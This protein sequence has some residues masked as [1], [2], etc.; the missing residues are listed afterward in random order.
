MVAFDSN[1]VLRRLE[2]RD[3]TAL[4][5]TLAGTEALL[6]VYLIQQ[7]SKENDAIRFVQHTELLASHAIEC[8]DS[9][10]LIRRSTQFAGE[11]WPVCYYNSSV[12][13]W[14][15]AAGWRCGP[16]GALPC[17]ILRRVRFEPKANENN[18]LSDAA[19]DSTA[20][21]VAITP[22][23]E[24]PANSVVGAPSRLPRVRSRDTQCLAEVEDVISDDD[25]SKYTL[26]IDESE[27]LFQPEKWRLTLE[28][29]ESRVASV[30]AKDEFRRALLRRLRQRLYEKLCASVVQGAVRAEESTEDAMRRWI[31][32]DSQ[33]IDILPETCPTL[34][35]AV[36]KARERPQD[37][38]VNEARRARQL[39]RSACVTAV[40]KIT[41]GRTFVCVDIGCAGAAVVARS[42][43]VWLVR[44]AIERGVPFFDDDDGLDLDSNANIL[45]I[46][47]NDDD[48]AETLSRRLDD[49]RL[50]RP[51][52][53]A[54]VRCSSRG[55]EALQRRLRGREESFPATLSQTLHNA[56]KRMLRRLDE[57]NPL[58]R[59]RD[60]T[61]AA[62]PAVQAVDIWLKELVFG[63][64]KES[65]DI[66]VKLKLFVD[67]SYA[68]EERN[69]SHTG[70]AAT[71]SI[72]L[73]LW[74]PLRTAGSA[75]PEPPEPPSLS[76][77]ESVIYNDDDSDDDQ[78][79]QIYSASSSMANLTPAAK[80]MVKG[81]KRAA[82]LQQHLVHEHRAQKL[83]LTFA[84]ST[85]ALLNAQGRRCA[86]CG[87]E[88]LHVSSFMGNNF[89]PCR[90]LDVLVCT[91]RCHSGDRRVLPWRAVLCGDLKPHRVCRAAAAFLDAR[92]YEP[93]LK[94]PP[95]A[96]IFRINPSVDAARQLRIL[97]AEIRTDA[98]LHGRVG[99]T[100][101]SRLLIS[102]LGASRIHLAINSPQFWSL[103]DLIDASQGHL[104]SI[105]SDIIAD[106]NEVFASAFGLYQEVWQDISTIN[107]D[108]N[109]K[110][111]S[112]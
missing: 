61:A 6:G 96:A 59:D 47:K 86:C 26:N 91:K 45:F 65:E 22:S 103:Q 19:D 64:E 109:E 35:A 16:A 90:L 66:A 112:P 55:L 58:G 56:E 93:L 30:T 40:R 76:G 106:A 23:Y 99:A 78:D 32:P 89:A 70:V 97:L 110:I 71:S 87:D 85:E 63:E 68:D 1:G 46:E 84:E 33:K 10:W 53:V 20:D 42:A 36:E 57:T 39:W 8:E 31:I 81:I 3:A 102:K 75:S 60:I 83:P 105:M 95:T 50:R 4:E 38:R 74:L 52:R 9:R 72:S 111:E 62:A 82:S 49:G 94:V 80:K 17:P 15:P 104:I 24:V 54:V 44:I 67:D 100:Q 108:D 11:E 25:T 101:A 73:G 79:G 21:T 69:R 77:L 37:L 28:E 88:V 7:V 34:E 18:T 41:D 107:N 12:S 51:R 13:P 2:T 29:H 43:V 5:V 27:I 14:P 48:P 98:T 92:R